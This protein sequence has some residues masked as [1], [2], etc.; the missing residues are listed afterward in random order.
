[1]FSSSLLVLVYFLDQV[2]SL[3]VKTVPSRRL[4]LSNLIWSGNKLCSPPP[5]LI[6]WGPTWRREWILGGNF[7][8]QIFPT[9][10][11]FH[12]QCLW[13]PP[14]NCKLTKSRE[15]TDLANSS[16]IPSNIWTIPETIFISPIPPQ[17]LF[18][19]SVCRETFNENTKS[20]IFLPIC[21]FNNTK[22][23]FNKKFNFLPTFTILLTTF[24]NFILFV[25]IWQFSVTIF[26]TF[27]V[28]NFISFFN[29]LG[30]F[31]HFL[32]RHFLTLLLGKSS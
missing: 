27:V 31:G 16:S 15:T 11:N 22:K 3:P 7:L 20:F 14:P 9:G 10:S 23:F 8:H 13:G 32:C 6:N 2:R 17:P 26:K 21:S 28:D 5:L 24:N 25:T 12:W 19:G 1:M 30:Q 18:P 4:V 29:N